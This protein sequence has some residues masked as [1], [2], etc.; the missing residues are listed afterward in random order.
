MPVKKIILYNA[1]NANTN[2]RVHVVTGNLNTIKS[3]KKLVGI[4]SKKKSCLLL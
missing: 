4:W 2:N 1:Y 3:L